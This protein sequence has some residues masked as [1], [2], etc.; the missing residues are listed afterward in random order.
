MYA[1]K[2]IQTRL[3]PGLHEEIK[4]RAEATGLSVN[5]WINRAIEYALA[6]KSPNMTVT[7]TRKVNL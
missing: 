5:E 6:A 4:L 1:R 3:R 7:E 2:N